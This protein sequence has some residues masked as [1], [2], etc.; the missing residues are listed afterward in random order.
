M[1]MTEFDLISEHIRNEL[2]NKTQR[3]FTRATSDTIIRILF[4]LAEA[5][6][7]NKVR[8]QQLE[9][10][11]RLNLSQNRVSEVLQLAKKIGLIKID[12]IRRCGNVR[13]EYTLLDGPI[14]DTIKNSILKKV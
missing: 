12:L 14:V 3:N 6:N 5:S 9:I 8:L 10:S 13:N 1:L 11:S 7:Y 2:K 4:I